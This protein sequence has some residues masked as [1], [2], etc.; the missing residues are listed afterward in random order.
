MRSF[1][2]P[3]SFCAD[4]PA[5]SSSCERSRPQPLS[6]S[7][8]ASAKVISKLG[9]MRRTPGKRRAGGVRTAKGAS[10]RA[11][12]RSRELEN[13]SPGYDWEDAFAAPVEVVVPAGL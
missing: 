1:A 11:D 13:Y 5:V 4:Q 7:I 3:Y 9:R 8:A 10:Q 6:A 2:S 12:E